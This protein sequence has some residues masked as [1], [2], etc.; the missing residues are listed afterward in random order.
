MEYSGICALATCHHKPVIKHMVDNCKLWGGGDY[1][2]SHL[3]DS[4][5]VTVVYLLIQ[6]IYH[7]ISS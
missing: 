3:P 2:A 1:S 6:K 5:I 7:I 4:V